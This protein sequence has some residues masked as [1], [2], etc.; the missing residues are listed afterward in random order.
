VTAKSLAEVHGG[1]AGGP[2]PRSSTGIVAVHECNELLAASSV[3]MRSCGTMPWRQLMEDKGPQEYT[4]D[5]HAFVKCAEA[6]SRSVQ[7][8]QAVAFA[9]RPGASSSL[10]SG[11]K[12]ATVCRSPLPSLFGWFPAHEPSGTRDTGTSM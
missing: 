12:P 4:P 9:V 1:C 5:A 8:L 6:V 2:S 7:P 10:C 3:S 11:T